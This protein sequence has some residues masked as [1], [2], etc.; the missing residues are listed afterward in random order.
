MTPVLGTEIVVSLWL[1]NYQAA[2]APGSVRNLASK[3]TIGK[4]YRRS[5]KVKLL[6]FTHLLRLVHP[7]PHVPTC[8]YTTP[9][10]GAAQ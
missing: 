2:T 10:G 5:S 6:L 7:Y 4:G 1:M 3:E 9:G 8:A